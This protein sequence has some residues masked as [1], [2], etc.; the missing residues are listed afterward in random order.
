MSEWFTAHEEVCYAFPWLRNKSREW[1]WI[2]GKRYLMY[3]LFPRTAAIA[4]PVTI[5]DVET[6]SIHSEGFL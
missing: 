5:I 1:R 3:W 6:L 4:Q 2:N